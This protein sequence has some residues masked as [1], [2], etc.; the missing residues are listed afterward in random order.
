MASVSLIKRGQKS[1]FQSF[2]G[3]N[4]DKFYI[5]Q[6]VM[7]KRSRNRVPSSQNTLRNLTN[8]PQLQQSIDSFFKALNQK[9]DRSAFEFTENL[10]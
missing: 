10:Q 2:F 4:R 3:Y 8:S 9:N 1:D 6:I 7:A 5:E